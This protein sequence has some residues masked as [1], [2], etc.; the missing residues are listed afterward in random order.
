MSTQQNVNVNAVSETPA[1]PHH[2]AAQAFIE[3]LRRMREAIPHFAIPTR[4]GNRRTVSSVAALP[5][6]F[7]ELAAVART[8]NP[9]LTR[10]DATTPA[11][12]RDLMNFADAFQP[13]A[14][15]LEAMAQFIRFSADSARDKAGSEALTT[16]A[17]A[18]RL[19]TRPEYAALVPYVADLRRALGGRGK[20][21]TAAKRKKQEA[22]STPPAA[23][24]PSGEK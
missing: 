3:Q 5:P 21:T 14:D 19:A 2:E 9:A 1:T 7:V 17:L 8:N 11:E 6:E 4:K 23:T 20:G 13:L 18:R 10:G 24:A 22:A 16:Y 15:E 12:T